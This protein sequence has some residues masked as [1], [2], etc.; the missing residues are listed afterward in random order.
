[1]H[2]ERLEGGTKT[3]RHRSTANTVF[4]VLDGNGTTTIGEC[5]FSWGKGDTFVAPTWTKIEHSIDSDA[6]LFTLSDEPLM[7]FAHYYRFEADGNSRDK[8]L[9]TNR[10]TGN[11]RDAR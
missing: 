2:V 8:T 9:L 5:R 1:L 4:L 7:R 10:Q 11:P 3:R 6:L